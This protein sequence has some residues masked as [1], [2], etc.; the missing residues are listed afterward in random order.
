MYKETL[1]LGLARA[2]VKGRYIFLRNWGGIQ[3][4]FIEK[5]LW[6]C[7]YTAKRKL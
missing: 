5:K 1:S 7:D 4:A 6:P 2:L 3:R